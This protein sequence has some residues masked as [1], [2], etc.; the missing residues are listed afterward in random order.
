M[1]LVIINTA[2]SA[3]KNAGFKVQRAYPGETIPAIT[4]VVA[5]VQL[6]GMDLT[7]GNSAVEAKILCPHALG[8]SACE[9][10]AVEAAEVLQ[11]AGFKS[12]VEAVTYDGRTGY[13]CA[14]CSASKQEHWFAT[15]YI[16]LKL[17]DLEQNWVVSFTAK[18]ATDE[19]NTDLGSVPWTVRVEQFFPTGEIEDKNPSSATFTLTNGSEVYNGCKWTSHQRI[20]EA[21]GIRQIR[22]GTATSRTTA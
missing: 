21:G 4:G 12:R 13:F 15:T 7:D 5:A 17:G 20:T 11:A 1:G 14:N 9:D 3:L 2:V 19:T 18:R 10:A 8:A 6:A 22:E 16:P